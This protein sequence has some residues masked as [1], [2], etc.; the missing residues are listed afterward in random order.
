ML[1]RF[2]HTLL[3]TFFCSGALVAAASTAFAECPQSTV[4]LIGKTGD[5]VKFEASTTSDAATAHVSY[6]RGTHASYDRNARVVEAR[7]EVWSD[8]A[9]DHYARATVVEHFSLHGVSTLPV[10]LRLNLTVFRAT[11]PGCR[12]A[13]VGGSALLA[14]NGQS[15]AATASCTGYINVP[16]IEITTVMHSAEPLQ[17]TYEVITRGWGFEPAFELTGQLEFVGIPEGIIVPCSTTLALE[18]STWGRVKALYR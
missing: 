12:T 14:A 18:N 10:T 8:E 17:V 15:A 7:S 13:L 4:Y 11:D 6:G 9:V 5:I 2:I 16:F 1:Q 3:L